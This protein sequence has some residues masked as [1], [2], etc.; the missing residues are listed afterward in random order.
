MRQLSSAE[1]MVTPPASDHALRL[2]GLWLAWLLVM[3]FHVELGLMPLF[4]GLSVEIRSR[5]PSARLPAIF[6]TMLIY[7]LLPV[8]ALLLLVQALSAPGG[9]SAAPWLRAGQFWF[10]AL[11]SLSN[12]IH[13]AADVRIPDA[14]GD[15]VLLMAVLTLIGLAINLEAWQWWQG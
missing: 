8:L 5:V 11:Y 1:A 4:H 10:S 2:A 6:L 9:W 14:R 13:L 12:A 3:L 15:Q 7:F